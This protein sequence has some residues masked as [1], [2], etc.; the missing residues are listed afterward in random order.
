MIMIAKCYFLVPS[1]KER[2]GHSTTVPYIACSSG[3]CNQAIEGTILTPEF[4]SFAVLSA[5]GVMSHHY[6]Y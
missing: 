1:I 5:S 4:S 3:L 6:Q 2:T